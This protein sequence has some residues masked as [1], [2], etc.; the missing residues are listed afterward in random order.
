[1]KS[2]KPGRA[3]AAGGALSFGR[4]AAFFGI[5]LSLAVIV[6]FVVAEAVLRAAPIPGITYH[7]FYYDEL[8]GQRYYPNT[9]FI[10]RNDRN[11]H[12][13]SRVNSWG[14]IDDEHS[15][16]K[17]AGTVRIGFFGDSFTEARQ[18][19]HDRAFHQLV[20][21]DLTAMSRPG[22]I[23]CIAVSMSGYG[24]LQSYL[25]YTRWADSL[26]LD[27]A[28]YVFCENDPGDLVPSIKQSDG[29]P[30][31]ILDGDSFSVD[32]S[33]RRIH[34][35]KTTRLHRTWQF[36]KSK[37]LLFSTLESRLKLLRRHGIKM[38]VKPE[39]MQMAEEAGR[40]EFPEPISRPSSWPDSLREQ[41]GALGERIIRRWRDDVS[42]D[43]RR[44]AVL[45]VPR[46]SEIDKPRSAQDSWALWLGEVCG[47]FG[48]DLVDPTPYLLARREQGE[49]LYYDHL[50]PGG[51]VA[52]ADAFLEHYQKVTRP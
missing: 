48:V 50:A 41:A 26:D 4:R 49:E 35:R 30:Y 42:R 29:I 24:P 18:V 37:T 47:R 22:A 11:D 51:H 19:P 27:W 15:V 39:E 43:G 28:V 38:T 7:T 12:V 16:A 46:Q 23:E 2:G 6:A 5:V 32:Y 14:Y 10:Y 34:K 40:E 36:L 3:D 44:F 31:P 8:T 20:E 25:E 13:R 33:F 17:P 1:M 45:Y 21:R 52:L 9:T